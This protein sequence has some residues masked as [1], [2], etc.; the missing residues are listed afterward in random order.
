MQNDSQTVEGRLNAHREILISLMTEALLTA[1]G[2]ARFLPILEQETLPVD[3][4]ED[5][6]ATP[7][8]GFARGNEKSEE[9]REIVETAKRRAEAVR[10]IAVRENDRIT[11]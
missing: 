10:R 2:G 7:S 5:P 8:A 1:D 3:G 11:P 4:S 9:I 6:G